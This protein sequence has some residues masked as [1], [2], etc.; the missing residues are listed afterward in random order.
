[1]C[2]PQ[3]HWQP[4]ACPSLGALVV[5]TQPSAHLFLGRASLCGL[6]GQAHYTEKGF[7]QEGPC[8]RGVLRNPALAALNMP[9]APPRGASET[10]PL[11][12]YAEQ[13][14]VWQGRD[15]GVRV[16]TGPTPTPSNP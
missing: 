8:C 3:G 6:Q 12:L 15:V 9:A 4:D 5:G 1:M 11:P 13:Q 10:S 16:G 14:D 7:G 2:F